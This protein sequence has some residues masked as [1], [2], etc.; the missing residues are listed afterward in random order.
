MTQK[1]VS[2]I[3]LLASL[4]ASAQTKLNQA[5]WQQRVDYTIQVA[6]NDSQNT[7]TGIETMVYYN[8]SPS[9]LSEIY[10]H[11]W[12][13]AYLDNQTP[14]ANQ[15]VVNGQTDFYFAQTEKRGKIDSLN[16]KVDGVKVKAEFMYGGYEVCKLILPKLLGSMQKVEITTSFRVKLPEV[17]SRMGHDDNL[18]CVT[19]WYPKPA[20][21]DVNGWNT[22]SYLDQG[23][24]Y[25]EFGKFD[26]SI[27]VPKDYV[28]AATG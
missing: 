6:L 5:S 8:N 17:F 23:E 12:P 11:L 15:Q 25:S 18:Y 20:V 24:F 7:L 13:N 2:F 21:Y 9:S 27:T 1:F 14:F 19:Q 16:F 22:M 4:T 10:I 3:C 26:V 28:V